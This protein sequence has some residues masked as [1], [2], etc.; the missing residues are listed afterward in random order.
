MQTVEV[1]VL[2]F[3]IFRANGTCRYV[4]AAPFDIECIVH[5]ILTSILHLLI[6][7]PNIKTK[8]FHY[9][10]KP[11][12]VTTS[13]KRKPIQNA[14]IFPVKAFHLEPLVSKHLL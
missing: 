1:T 11:P 2:L 4:A 10:V 13:H 8:I 9:T 14:K 7:S 12:S 3:L 6:I 5:S